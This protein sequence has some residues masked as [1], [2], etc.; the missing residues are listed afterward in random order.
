M[1]EVPIGRQFSSIQ[2]KSA[3]FFIIIRRQVLSLAISQNKVCFSEKL[4][5]C[6]IGKK[7]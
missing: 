4:K 5:A 7:S 6:I 3:S 1:T 2:S